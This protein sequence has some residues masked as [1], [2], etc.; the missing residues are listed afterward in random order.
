MATKVLGGGQYV[1]ITDQIIGVSQLL[2]PR[3]QDASPQST[4][5]SPFASAHGATTVSIYN[6][7]FLSS[8]VRDR[9][10]K[11]SKTP[12]N[13]NRRAAV[14]YRQVREVARDIKK[15]HVNSSDGY[16]TN[17]NIFSTRT[18]AEPVLI[19]KILAASIVYVDVS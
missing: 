3:V 15:L 18:S 17:E 14:Y 11:I 7:S 10:L 9:K 13:T 2:G 16:N 19:T 6:D 8:E 12:F 4:P 5:L 1:A